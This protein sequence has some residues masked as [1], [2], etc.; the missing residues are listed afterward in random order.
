LNAPQALE[1]LGVDDVSNDVW[2][3]EASMHRIHD[4]E[5]HLAKDLLIARACAILMHRDDRRVINGIH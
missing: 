4:L 1:E 2:K 3:A 5:D